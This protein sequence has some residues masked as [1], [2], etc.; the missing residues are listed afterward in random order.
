MRA[1]GYGRSAARRAIEEWP[2]VAKKFTDRSVS[3][4]TSLSE[5]VTLITIGCGLTLFGRII[6]L[7]DCLWNGQ[8]R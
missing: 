5:S 4:S 2:D 6:M 7:N 3:S 8:V 1:P